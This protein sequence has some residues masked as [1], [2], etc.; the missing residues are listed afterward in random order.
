MGFVLSNRALKH[1]RFLRPLSEKGRRPHH[2]GAVAVPTDRSFFAFSG[3]N[4]ADSISL[5]SESGTF[6]AEH[7][8][9]SHATA[10]NTIN[11]EKSFVNLF[12]FIIRFER[13]NPTN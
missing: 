3:S 8:G 6:P 5:F 4:L 7:P 13:G 2:L 11:M 10:A 1:E 9:L 12:V